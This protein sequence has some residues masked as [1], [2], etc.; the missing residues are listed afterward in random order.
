MGTWDFPT[1]DPPLSTLKY[2]SPDHKDTH[3]RGCLAFSRLR[4]RLWRAKV[5][6]L[7]ERDIGVVPDTNAYI[8][9]LTY[10]GI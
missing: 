10:R 7:F 8:H 6:G 5:R 4:R 2:A 9:V 3:E 1:L